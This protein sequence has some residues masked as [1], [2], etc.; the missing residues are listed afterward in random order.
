M[1][2]R[3]VRRKKLSDEVCEQLEQM[4]INGEFEPNQK[5]KSEAELAAM[6]NVSKTVIRE[7]LSVL[8]AKGLIEGRAGS[9]NYLREQNGE[10]VVAS[11]ASTVLINR[12]AL[13]ELLELR[14][15]LEVEAASLA[16]K[17]ATSEDIRLLKEANEWL[18]RSNATGQLDEAIESDFE[19]HK[20]LFDA[21]HNSVFV[22]VF[23]SIS[24][25]FKEGITAT[26]TQSAHIKGR[27][28][29]GIEEHNRI[30][31][32][33][34]NRS[35]RDARREMRQHLRNNESKTWKLDMDQADPENA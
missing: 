16:A 10:S 22:K 18:A 24:A 33:I 8:K 26:K 11:F 5:M 7:A 13:I 14:R 23:Q 29:E 31:A 35:S 9:G 20:R 17:R 3:S 12:D 25:I 15:G 6:F 30:I 27:H 1:T 34:E 32:A 2:I 19:F 21:T 4:I 28:L